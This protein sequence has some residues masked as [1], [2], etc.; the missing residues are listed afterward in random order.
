MTG[1]AI[2]YNLKAQGQPV[3]TLEGQSLFDSCICGSLQ[4]GT[5]HGSKMALG[6]DWEMGNWFFR[7]SWFPGPSVHLGISRK[8]GV[9]SMPENK[10]IGA[11]KWAEL[12]GGQDGRMGAISMGVAQRHDIAITPAEHVQTRITGVQFS[13]HKDAQ[14]QVRKS[15]A[16]FVE[17]GGQHSPR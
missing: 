3:F 2:S 1:A 13:S 16:M 8:E 17:E 11:R 12:G 5:V 10:A 7:L 9:G 15:W 6:W 4:A 14:Y